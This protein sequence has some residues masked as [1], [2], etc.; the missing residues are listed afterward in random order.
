MFILLTKKVIKRKKG[1][2][3]INAF[4]EYT[5][6]Q[7]FLNQSNPG[8]DQM[9]DISFHSGAHEVG[10]EMVVMFAKD[11]LVKIGDSIEYLGLGV[12]SA[13]AE[14]E[15]IRMIAEGLNIT[16][17]NLVL[18]DKDPHLDG[19]LKA[20]E[21]LVPEEMSAYLKS[22]IGRGKSFNVMSALGMEFLFGD[23]R[24][25]K[26]LFAA[27]SML[28]RQGGV[29]I[30]TEAQSIYMDPDKIAAKFGMKKMLNGCFVKM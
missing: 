8:P 3:T 28:L 7:E 15:M 18:V 27:A 1:Y 4:E 17:Q 23:E 13:M 12:G 26:A 19:G 25:Y 30:M 14:R 5:R 21:T 20:N 24:A 10:A 11:G 29:L 9:Q 16:K 6:Y 22:A 2:V